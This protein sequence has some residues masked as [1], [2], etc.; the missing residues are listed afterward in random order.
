ML[1]VKTI[2]K[3]T[4]ELQSLLPNASIKFAHG[5][6]PERELEQV[7]VDFYANFNLLFGCTVRRRVVDKL[8][9]EFS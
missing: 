4:K 3:I 9:G 8:P 5:Q 2:E 1:K 6:M 7:M